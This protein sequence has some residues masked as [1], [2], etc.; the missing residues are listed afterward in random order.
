MGLFLL[1]VISLVFLSFAMVRSA[2]WASRKRPAVRG[3]FGLCLASISSLALGFLLYLVLL[4]FEHK[5]PAGNADFPI[6]TWL[7]ISLASL[8]AALRV[9]SS[10]HTIWPPFALHGMFLLAM[11]SATSE[12]WVISVALMCVGLIATWRARVKGRTR[13][14]RE[15]NVD[16]TARPRTAS[17]QRA[18]E[19]F[20]RPA[21]MAPG[22]IQALAGLQPLFDPV[23]DHLL[24]NAIQGRVE[25]YWATVPVQI[26]RPYD[27]DYDPTK[28]P[29]GRLGV[30]AFDRAWRLG[31]STPV[32]LYQKGSEFVLSDDYVVW[33]AVK[34]LHVE[35]VP[36][37][38]LGKPVHEGLRDIVGPLDQAAVRNALGWG[39]A[40]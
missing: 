20:R 16:P 24:E 7:T 28:H 11:H 6:F 26:I 31:N 38:I 3:V 35:S 27:P 37:L 23:F 36:A 2:D 30:D 10:V 4:T 22:E 14:S 39:P 32:W 40:A 33:E 19:T 21:M 25:V 13:I 29:V 8:Y 17:F 9:R 1:Y 15:P 34:A 5:L 18:T 12:Y